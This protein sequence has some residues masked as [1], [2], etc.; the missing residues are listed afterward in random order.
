MDRQ[1]ALG[2]ASC[3]LLWAAL[4]VGDAAA[5]QVYSLTGRY[6]DQEGRFLVLPLTGAAAC[7]DFV[8]GTASQSQSPAPKTVPSL[9]TRALAFA[10]CAPGAATFSTS[11][12]DSPAAVG[13]RLTVP[14]GF[15]AQPAQL[16]VASL[17]AGTRTLQVATSWAFGGPQ[18]ASARLTPVG[19][20]MANGAN[21]APWRVLQAGAWTGQ[22]GRAGATFTWCPGVGSGCPAPSAAASGRRMIV[23]NLSGTNSPGGFGGTMSAVARAASAFSRVVR[24]Q[25]LFGALGSMSVAVYPL[26]P[27]AGPH[28]GCALASASRGAGRGYA[29]YVARAQPTGAV[30]AAYTQ[31]PSGLIAG[32][33]VPVPAPTAVRTSVHFPWTTGRVIVRRTGM[34]TAGRVDVFTISA[35]GDDS[36]SAMG[37]RNI[38]LVAGKLTTRVVSGSLVF[39]DVGVAQQSLSVM[40]EP[41]TGV[42]CL[43]GAVALLGLA[44]RRA[45]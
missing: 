4:A 11:G 9:A 20:S 40:P 43:A 5:Q 7:A 30:Y 17:V 37:A 36:V 19:G 34:T 21:T 39:N 16:A 23:K 18:P 10:G 2:V 15:L 32:S 22:T 8:W 1:R 26:E 25:P 45:R 6:A 28:S 35:A 27:C 14:T 42:A 38:Q 44:A 29:A 31:T 41:A 13:G 24:R 12:S 33:G 3:A